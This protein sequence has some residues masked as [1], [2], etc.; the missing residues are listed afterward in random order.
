MEG[1]T[2]A[3]TLR[4]DRTSFGPATA[5][6]TGDRVW[7]LTVS[8]RVP[9][10]IET[11]LGVGRTD[12][13]LTGLIVERLDVEHGLGQTVVV[14]PEEGGLRARIEG[15]IGQTVVIIPGTVAARMRLDTG[16]AAQQVP[17]GYVCDDDLCTSPGYETAD[18]RVELEL[19]QAIGSL[20]V[21]H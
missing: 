6:W 10:L 1:D 14:L 9:L 15:A 2:G 4:T 5:G 16:L 17:D 3:F 21:R 7:D 18:Q 8:D 13:D 20:V 19:G 11:D 12:L